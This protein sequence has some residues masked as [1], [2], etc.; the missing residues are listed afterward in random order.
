VTGDLINTCSESFRT[1]AHAGCN[2]YN[3]AA[4][5]EQL[6]ERAWEAF[7]ATQRQERM[8]H[9]NTYNAFIR[10]DRRHDH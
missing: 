10:T 9:V 5:K 3:V 7:D 8:P 1:G 6:P 4:E 2:T